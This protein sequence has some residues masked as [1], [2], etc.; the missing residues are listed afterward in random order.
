MSKRHLHGSL[1]PYVN[2]WERTDQGVER[3]HARRGDP[4]LAPCRIKVLAIEPDWYLTQPLV[5]FE[6]LDEDTDAGQVPVRRRTDHRA[7]RGPGSC[8][9]KGQVVARYARTGA[10]IE[11]GVVD[12]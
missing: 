9:D 8:L 7:S 12:P 11:Y 4:I 10:G 5:Y 6:L 1:L 2:H 3:Q